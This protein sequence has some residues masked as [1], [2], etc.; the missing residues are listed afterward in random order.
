MM[1]HVYVKCTLRKVMCDCILYLCY[2]AGVLQMVLK[3]LCGS[4]LKSL[5]QSCQ[6]HAELRSVELEQ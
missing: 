6:Q 5:R 1:N 4:V 3:Q 2:V